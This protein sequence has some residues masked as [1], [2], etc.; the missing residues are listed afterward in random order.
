MH[1]IWF[2][3][4]NQKQ[5]V[6][7]YSEPMHRVSKKEETKQQNQNGMPILKTHFTRL[8][9][10]PSPTPFHISLF[11]MVL[12]ILCC[13]FD[14]L[15]VFTTSCARWNSYNVTAFGRVWNRY[16][17]MITHCNQRTKEMN[18]T[19]N[20]YNYALP[21]KIFYRQQINFHRSGSRLSSRLSV[22]GFRVIHST[23]FLL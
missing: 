9:R 1:R 2:I 13:C 17:Q 12:F 10:P 11:P 20:L 6:L 4:S 14:F 22:V 19:A 16:C 7:G 23:G 5:P 15:I 3:F 21:T 8:F 18:G